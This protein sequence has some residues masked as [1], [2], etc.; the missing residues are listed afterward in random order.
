MSSF[1]GVAPSTSYVV[2]VV[3]RIRRDIWEFGG[4]ANFFN[5]DVK[6]VKVVRCSPDGHDNPR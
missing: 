1:V 5:R 6:R 4:Y 3:V 2:A